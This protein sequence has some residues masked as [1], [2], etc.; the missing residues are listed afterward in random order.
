[1]NEESKIKIIF[2]GRQDG[3]KD[4]KFSIA[5][6]RYCHIKMLKE[7]EECNKHE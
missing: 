4:L 3:P 1:M 2:I 5:I 7:Q 6:A